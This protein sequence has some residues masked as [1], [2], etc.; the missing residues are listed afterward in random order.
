M[1]FRLPYLY[2]RI[3]IMIGVE[4]PVYYPI[5]KPKTII[6][7]DLAADIVVSE[8]Q[9]SRKHLIIVQEGDQYF[10]VDQGSTNGSYLNEERLVPGRKTEF[11]SYFPVR[12]GSSVLV[13]LVTDQEAE[14]DQEKIS[15]PFPGDSS[16]PKKNPLASQSSGDRTTVIS[17]K[18]LQNT[19]TDSLVKKRQE[20]KKKVS[21]RSVKEEPIKKKVKKKKNPIKL[22]HIVVALILLPA[23]YFTFI[24]KEAPPVVVEVKPPTV[25]EKVAVAKTQGVLIDPASKEIITQAF[26][27]AKCQTEVE[28]VLCSSV[29]GAGVENW[30]AVAVDQEM[31]VV[32]ADATAFYEEAKTLLPPPAVPEADPSGATPVAEPSPAGAAPQQQQVSYQEELWQIAAGIFVM[33][34]ITKPNYKLL[35]GKKLTFALYLLKEGAPELKGTLAITAKSLEVVKVLLDRRRLAYIKDSRAQVMNFTSEYYQLNLEPNL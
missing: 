25:E 3:E 24:G 32:I 13:S 28:K 19:R 15:I 8:D 7:S 9:I 20:Y 11:T 16:K 21:E 1:S 27:T 31:I 29:K 18:D 35:E 26:S 30:G 33:D 6:G 5:N 17:L 2:M 23:L 12:L 10:V 14:E 34:G 4:N 22:I